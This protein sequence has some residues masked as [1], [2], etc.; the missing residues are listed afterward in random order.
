[1]VDTDGHRTR[2]ILN[3]NQVLFQLSY[4]PIKAVSYS[5]VLGTSVTLMV[6]ASHSTAGIELLCT[7][8][9]SLTINC[10]PL[11]AHVC[12]NVD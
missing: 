10:S 1:M 9:V 3:A 7:E 8:F 6:C 2:N 4:W 5:F 11:Q 12:F